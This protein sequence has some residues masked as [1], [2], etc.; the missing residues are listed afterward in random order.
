MRYHI[1]DNNKHTIY[2]QET[3]KSA[4]NE[5]HYYNDQDCLNLTPGLHEGIHKM[6][7][8][9]QAK[10]KKTLRVVVAQSTIK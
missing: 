9:T 2:P 7:H 8:T 4:D 3:S 10:K 1:C 5:C 6:K